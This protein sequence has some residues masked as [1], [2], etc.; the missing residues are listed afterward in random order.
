MHQDSIFYSNLIVKV[1]IFRFINCFTSLFYYAFSVRNLAFLGA[2]LFSFMCAGQIVNL[3][4]ILG[5]PLMD[6]AVLFLFLS[7]ILSLFHPVKIIWPF[8]VRRFKLWRSSYVLE[9]HLRI[10][11]KE[12]E[13]KMSLRSTNANLFSGSINPEVRISPLRVKIDNVISLSSPGPGTWSFLSSIS[14]AHL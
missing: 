13:T 11:E 4:G 14:G 10:R 9:Q 2:Q 1:F 8:G 12:I 7:K 6:N 3:I 5:L